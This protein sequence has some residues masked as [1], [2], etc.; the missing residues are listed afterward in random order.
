MIILGK[1]KSGKIVCVGTGKVTSEPRFAE[2]KTGKSVCSFF[3]NSDVIGKGQSREYESYK[4]NA[5]DEKAHYARNFEKGDTIYVEGECSK[6]DYTSQKNGKDE[7]QI[8]ASELRSADIGAQ[9][10]NLQ[11]AVN[12]LIKKVYNKGNEPTPED[13]AEMFKDVELPEFLQEDFASGI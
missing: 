7:Y 6:D 9:V 3:V 13:A 10:A 1:T 8:T 12:D 5:W 11:L 2:T 4:V